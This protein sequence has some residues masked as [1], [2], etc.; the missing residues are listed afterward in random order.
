MEG[1]KKSRSRYTGALTKAM[2]KLKLLNFD[3]TASIK[4]LDVDDIER[5]LSSIERTEVNF[6]HT[7]EEALDFIPDGEDEDDFHDAEAEILETFEVN[8]SKAKK[9]ATHLITLKGI[10]TGLRDLV[11]DMS[12]LETSLT[13][14]PDEDHSIVLHSIMTAFS[15]LRREWKK[16]NLPEEHP[17][18][19]ELNSFN[20]EIQSLAAST[21]SAKHRSM[22]M[23]ESAAHF[24]VP[25]KTE[26]NLT[27]LPAISLPT[28]LGDVLK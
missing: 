21:T 3:D 17:M 12:T 20:K 28:F 14:R 7:G 19:Q 8:A 24:G 18:K 26:K 22:P 4:A 2:H 25:I 23:P 5:I 9:L 13:E 11:F 15:T 6:N 27:K 10:Q 1:V 16:T